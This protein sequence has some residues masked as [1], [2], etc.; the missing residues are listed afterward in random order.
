MA[1]VG[2][3][4]GDGV[5]YNGRPGVDVSDKSL[6]IRPSVVVI[7]AAALAILTINNLLLKAATDG[8]RRHRRKPAAS[9]A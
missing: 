5:R 9:E 6:L 2:R 4:R 8:D 3:R 1:R 7:T